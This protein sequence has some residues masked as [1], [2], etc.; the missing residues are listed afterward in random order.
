MS[1]AAPRRGCGL[2]HGVRPSSHQVIFKKCTISI[3]YKNTPKM[4]RSMQQPPDIPNRAETTTPS[5]SPRRRERTASKLRPILGLKSNTRPEPRPT[6]L[7]RLN[8]L[9]QLKHVSIN[10]GRAC[11][12]LSPGR[13]ARVG[14]VSQAMSEK[15]AQRG[16]ASLEPAIGFASSHSRGAHVKRPGVAGVPRARRRRSCKGRS[17]IMQ[18]MHCHMVCSGGPTGRPKHE[19]QG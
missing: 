8:Y 3:Y 13:A 11:P 18:P 19:H 12:L 2:R 4:K 1:S 5:V 9:L 10:S 14:P 6:L 16:D 7:P 17:L 15:R